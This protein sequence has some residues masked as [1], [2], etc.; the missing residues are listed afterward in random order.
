MKLP[1]RR[2][3]PQESESSIVPLR[4]MMDRLFEDSFWSPFELMRRTPQMISQG[5]RGGW[6]PQVDV[7]ETDKEIRVKVNAPGVDPNQV[8]ISVEEDVLTI[9]GRTEEKRE[10]KG[11]NFYRLEREYGSFQRSMELPHGADTDK[12]EATAKNGV[13][14]IMIS[15]KP[16]SRRKA[17]T[18]KVQDKSK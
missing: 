10:E 17:I 16:E 5:S 11:E 9:S 6:M 1:I 18:V 3:Q 2:N 4:D 14:H 15:K 8:N 7:S 13:I 12:I